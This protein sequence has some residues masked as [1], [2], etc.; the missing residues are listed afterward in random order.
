MAY[1]HTCVTCHYRVTVDPGGPPNPEQAEL[2][3]GRCLLDVPRLMDV[4][5]LYGPANPGLTSKFMQQVCACVWG[6]RGAAALY[7]LANPGLTGKF[8]RQVCLGGWRWGGVMQ[9]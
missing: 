5:A 2:L 8:M 6:R 7:G 1:V 4:A 3:Y 9:G